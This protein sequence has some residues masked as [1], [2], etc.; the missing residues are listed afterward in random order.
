MSLVMKNTKPTRVSNF[1]KTFVMLLL[2]CVIAV[3]DVAPCWSIFLISFL[4]LV[5]LSVRLIDIEMTFASYI[6]Q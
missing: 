6:S 3:C 1:M 5:L 4:C 2:H